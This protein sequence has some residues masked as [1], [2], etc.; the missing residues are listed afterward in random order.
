MGMLCNKQTG[1]GTHQ[2]E[3]RGETRKEHADTHTLLC[4]ATARAGIAQMLVNMLK[5]KNIKQVAPRAKPPRSNTGTAPKQAKGALRCTY[6]CTCRFS[7]SMH[8]VK[9]ATDAMREKAA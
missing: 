8:Y 5:L 1:E 4:N 9:M 6:T 7:Y 3:K 2:G